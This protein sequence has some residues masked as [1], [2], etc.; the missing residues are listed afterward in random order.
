MA[1]GRPMGLARWMSELQASIATEHHTAE[2]DGYKMHFWK[3]GTG[4]DLLILHGILGTAAAWEDVAP[5][6]A[7]EFTVYAIDAL[8]IGR[9]ERVKGIDA[10]LEA[11][12]DRVARFMEARGIRAADILATSHGGA[13]ALM[14]AAKHPGRVRSL[15]LN[16]PANPF[17]NWADPLIR[18]YQSPLGRWF[19]HRIPDLPDAV[20]ALA[21]GRMYGDETAAQNGHLEKYMDSL[22]IPGTV[23]YV[24]SILSRWFEDMRDLEQKLDQVH[25]FPALLVWGDRDC[26]VSLESGRRLQRLFA[27]SEL[28]VLPGAGHLPFEECPR[29]FGQAITS[30]LDRCRAEREPGPKL[31]TP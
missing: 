14:L 19:A 9:S 2:V 8:G 27:R 21:L 1:W 10:G 6:L 22:R 18:F 13:V 15:I 23:D 4:P 12:A 29:I 11:Q 17:S 28:V 16:S 7:P 20:T 30:F 24:L 25:G 26:A 3:A 5:E 31:V